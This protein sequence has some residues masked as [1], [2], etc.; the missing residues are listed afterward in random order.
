MIP[1]WRLSGRLGNQMFEY[2]YLY[3]EM[4]RGNIQDVYVQ[5][6]EYF[7]EFADEIRQLYGQ[8]IV[9]IDMVAIHVRRADYV[10]NTFYVDVFGNGYYERAMAE[11]PNADFLVFSDDIEWCKQ[12]DIF[13]GCEFSDERDEIKDL[14]LMAGCRGIIMANSSYSWW[15]AFLGDPNKKVVAPKEWYTLAAPHDN[16]ESVASTRLP[17]RWLRV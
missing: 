5:S 2:A 3:A 17:D 12:Q 14:N 10:G 13:K 9:P 6:E 16:E 8:D 7:E 4:R 11:F 15:A 1:M